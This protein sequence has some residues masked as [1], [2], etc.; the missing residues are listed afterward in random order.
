MASD[1]L[2]SN[3]RIIDG[4][5]SPWFEGDIEI[6]DGTIA[7]IH[8]GGHERSA[9]R[10]IDANGNIVCPGFIDTH[11]HSDIELFNDPTLAPKIQ[12]GITTEILGQDGFSMTPLYREGAAKEWED[13]LSGL[14]GRTERSLDWEST[15][16]YFDAIESNGIAPNVAMLIGHGTVRYNVLGMSDKKP[17]EDQLDE[18]GDLVTESL[19]QGAIGFSTGLVYMPQYNSDTHEVQELA[20][21]LKPYKRPFVAH[22][23]RERFGIWEAFDEF[24]DIGAEEGIPLHHSHFKLIGAPNHGKADRALELVEYARDRGID[25][26]GDQYPYLAG[27]TMLTALLPPWI[28]QQSP[29]KMLDKLQDPEIRERLEKDIEEWRIDD[30]RNPGKYSGWES[31][32]ISS[33][34]STENEKFVG[35]NVLEISTEKGVSPV[36]TIC[37]LLVEEDLQVTMTLHHLNEKDMRKILQSERICVSTDGIFGGGKPH[38]RLYGT[39]PKILGK[40]VRE[41]NLLSVEAAIRKMTSLPARIFNLDAKG[42]IRPGM[43]ADLVIFDPDLIGS[44]ATFERPRQYPDGVENVLVNGE[45]VV[46]DTEVTGEL[47]GEVI[48]A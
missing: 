46:E 19:E 30:W 5:G 2:I 24:M 47:P 4:T 39:Y 10:H 48:R 12:Q 14:N 34:N 25:Y 40:Y 33:V 13:H 7:A 44:T 20:A 38:P 16:D 8:R 45:V 26:V 42:I 36:S 43:D 32:R 29:G 23:R 17:T 1:L 37:D 9:E 15:A 31:I 35:K 6:S 28:K 21:R 18:M 3:G 27:S 41:E 11:S 22:I